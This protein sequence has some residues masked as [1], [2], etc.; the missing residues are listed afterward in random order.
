MDHFNKVGSKVIPH[1]SVNILDIQRHDVHTT[2]CI[3]NAI[4][5]QYQIQTIHSILEVGLEV[6]HWYSGGE[7]L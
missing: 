1:I 5:P 7:F 4:H 3:G 2:L 6:L